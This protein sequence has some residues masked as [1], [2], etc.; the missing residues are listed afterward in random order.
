MRKKAPQKTK[1][2]TNILGLAATGLALAAALGFLTV[3]NN[4]KSTHNLTNLHKTDATSVRPAV[5][6]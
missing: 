2:N 4:D 5:A 3:S 6:K 1:S